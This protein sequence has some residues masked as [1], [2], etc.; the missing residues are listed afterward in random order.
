MPTAE[1]VAWQPYLPQH[2]PL[3]HSAL[4]AVILLAVIHLPRLHLLSP[5]LLS[6]LPMAAYRHPP[7][8]SQAAY[9]QTTQT[10]YLQ[11]A[12][13]PTPLGTTTKTAGDQVHLTSLST[14]T[15]MPCSLSSYSSSLIF[16]RWISGGYA[17]NKQIGRILTTL[18]PTQQ[19]K[20]TS[21]VCFF[22]Y[23]RLLTNYS[24]S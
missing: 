23:L 8:H 10:S 19:K 9:W 20:H 14:L 16:I 3:P 15:G 7:P 12:T 6:D 4:P 13:K 2:L 17:V 18:H 21:L 24:P 22:L 1:A 11:A 5:H